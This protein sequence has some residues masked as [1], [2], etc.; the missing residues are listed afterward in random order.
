MATG[1]FAFAV[2]VLIANRLGLYT[3]GKADEST[4]FRYGTARWLMICV[5][6][7]CLVMVAVLGDSLDKILFSIRL[8][9]I[10]VDAVNGTMAGLAVGA[11]V[12]C[13]TYYSMRQH[14]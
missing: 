5:P 4:S 3:A 9:S 12:Y 13:I 11:I 14:S 2:L 10:V 6:L 7:A 1:C 8:S